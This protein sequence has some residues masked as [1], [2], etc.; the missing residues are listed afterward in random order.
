MKKMYILFSL[1]ALTL[2]ISACSRTVVPTT[3][4]PSETEQ[5]SEIPL[6]L[7]DQFLDIAESMPGFAGLYHTEDGKLKVLTAATSFSTQSVK[8]IAGIVST[9]MGEEV[10][11]QPLQPDIAENT[12]S[13]QAFDGL[14]PKQVD[15]VLET[16]KYSFKDL[17][18]WRSQLND[19]WSQ[20]GVN[21]VDI[22]EQAN[23][24]EIAVT[25]DGAARALRAYTTQKGIPEDALSISIQEGAEAGL[26]LRNNYPTNIGGLQ[27]E[28]DGAACTLGFN[29]RLGTLSG[30]VT[31]AH[32]STQQG[33]VTPTVYR[34]GG[35]QI[36]REFREAR[37]WTCGANR[38]RWADA[39]FVRYDAG[40]SF[41]S[42][43]IAFT[44]TNTNARSETS[45]SASDLE[46]RDWTRMGLAFRNKIIRG[47][48]PVVGDFVF[49]TGRTTG[50]TSGRVTQTCVDVR[51]NGTNIIN[52]CQTLANYFARGGDSGSPVYQYRYYTTTGWRVELKGINWSQGG[53]NVFSPISNVN[54]ALGTNLGLTRPATVRTRYDAREGS[55]PDFAQL[56]VSH[57]DDLVTID[58]RFNSSADLARAGHNIYLYGTNRDTISFS[59]TSFSILQDRDSNGHFERTITSGSTRQIGTSTLRI[60]FSSRYLADIHQ[61]QV[62]AYSQTSRDRIPSTG[63]IQ[64]R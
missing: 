19:I 31:N 40:E 20:E 28:F 23:T 61:K 7:D 21:R 58:L 26:S 3:P 17:L 54:T 49:K 30:F 34:Q 48:N 4:N 24:I 45:A 64:M 39:A 37:Q 16:V 60:Q 22:D 2:V 36:G 63:Y 5:P 42:G 41:E 27:I 44:Y 29:A 38:C 1:L 9:V 55:S 11:Q 14:E 51:Q 52:R 47:S 43:G 59:R 6:T 53:S 18:G 10:L 50:T 32:C 25:D 33:V 12:L 8:D 62:W 57:T 35:D 56:T 13:T 46:I 15:I